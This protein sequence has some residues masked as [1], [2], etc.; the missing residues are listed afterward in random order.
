MGALRSSATMLP[1]EDLGAP[2]DVFWF[3]VGKKQQEG[4]ALRGNVER[5]RLLVMIDRG[6]LLAMRLPDSEGR[7]RSLPGAWDRRDPGRSEESRAAELDLAR[8]GRHHDLH[9]LTRQARPPDTL[10]KA[11]AAGDRRRCPRHVSDRRHRHQPRDPGRG[12][13]RQHPRRRHWPAARRSIRC[14]T[15]SRIAGCSRRA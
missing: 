10:A 6:D 3:R 15:G 13:G 4:S 1:L 11:G 7:R 5:G 9:L 2:M 14:S 8:A 12:R